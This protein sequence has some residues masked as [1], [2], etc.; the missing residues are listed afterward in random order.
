MLGFRVGNRK[1]GQEGSD[2]LNVTW[3]KAARARIA[4]ACVVMATVV[5]VVALTTWVHAAQ[6]HPNVV[7]IVLDTVRDDY[8]GGQWGDVPLTPAVDAIAH[9]ATRF[10]SAFTTAPWT[11]PSHASLF[12]GLY[13]H[14]HQ[15]VHE[16]FALD[17]ALVT[18]A[19][20]LQAAGYA[21]G[22]FT[23][24]PWL[25]RAL[26]FDQGFEEYTEV[27]RYAAESKHH[28][29]LAST[30]AID[31]L[32]QRGADRRPF[33]LFV[34][35]LEAHLPYA[36]PPYVARRL[37][38]STPGNAREGFSVAEAERIIAGLDEPSEA[39]LEEVRRLYAAEVAYQDTQVARV[40]DHLRAH[41]LLDETL[42]I[43]VADHG[44]HL[45]EHGLMG[46][47]FTL[48]EPVLRIPMIVRYPDVFPP[49]QAVDAPVSLI[50]VLPTILDVLELD[51][52]DAALPGVSL[53]GL[54]GPGVTD[55][56]LLAEYARPRT[57]IHQHWRSSQPDVDMSRFD[58]GLWSLRMGEFKYIISGLGDERLYNLADDPGEQHDLSMLLPD[59]LAA[60]RERL[61]ELQ[62][63]L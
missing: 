46:H 8:V 19:E 22:G 38:E 2:K 6:D 21:T 56:P 41:E 51:G 53:R 33:L 23:C 4:L 13:P 5:G 11:I 20:R 61:A 44:E 28:A 42:L 7:I 37:A 14:S 54:V 52:G 10:L 57:L 39:D 60:M 49:A 40:L 55:R 1:P 12:T 16:R 50:D 36:P 29:D 35:Y 32:R 15:A 59:R 45:G 47:E 58:A 9:E 43:I 24:N 30:M 34:N 63:E 48:H 3:Y 18:L 27:Y 31:W 17:G 26:G 25:N 62:K